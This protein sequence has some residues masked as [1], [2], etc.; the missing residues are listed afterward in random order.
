KTA[1]KKKLGDR[2]SSGTWTETLRRSVDSKN[3]R[4]ELRVL[5]FRRVE[6]AEIAQKKGVSLCGWKLSV[7]D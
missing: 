3:K 6:A 1:G 4:L 5:Y 2:W 7:S